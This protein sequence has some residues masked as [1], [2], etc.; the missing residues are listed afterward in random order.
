MGENLAAAVLVIAL[1]AAGFWLIDRL[2]D[3]S[4]AMAC[5]ESGH[6]WCRKL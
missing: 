3:Y 6:R 5:L 2:I 1:V 4:K